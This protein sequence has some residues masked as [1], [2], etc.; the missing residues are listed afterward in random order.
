M[1]AVYNPNLKP[2]YGLFLKVQRQNSNV[3]V[4]E[5][6]SQILLNAAG[7]VKDNV[8]DLMRPV[9]TEILCAVQVYSAEK[10]SD[11]CH[12]FLDVEA[13][14]LSFSFLMVESFENKMDHEILVPEIAFTS[15]PEAYFSQ[16]EED[17]DDSDDS[18]EEEELM[19]QEESPGTRMTHDSKVS[20]IDGQTLRLR[21]LRNFLDPIILTHERGESAGA[22]GE[23]RTFEFSLS[24]VDDVTVG[25]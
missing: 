1:L 17:F 10:A 2:L 13:R 16:L 8:K 20:V 12:V 22:T 6:N 9:Q 5:L 14:G 3:K 7:R 24:S 11:L 19:D 25:K 15:L 21:K 18:D 23:A 4:H